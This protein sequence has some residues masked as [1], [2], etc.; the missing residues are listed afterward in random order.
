MKLLRFFYLLF[1]F[2]SLFGCIGGGGSTDDNSQSFVVTPE[3]VDERVS[4]VTLL[5]TNNFQPAD[6]QSPVI[7]T[8]IARDSS[9]TPLADV[10]VSL[11]S[12]SDFAVFIDAKGVTGEN[13]R[14]TTGIV[15]SEAEVFEITAIAGG[16]LSKSAMVN[17]IAPVE[18]I[19]LTTPSTVL[20]VGDSST[21]IATIREVDTLTPL[22]R[23]PL[24]VSVSGHASVENVPTMSNENGQAIFTVSDEIGETVELTVTSGQL[25]KT[26]I[27]YFGAT[28]TL[29][30]ASINTLNTAQ[31]TALL[32]SHDGQPIVGETI[33]FNFLGENNETLTPV[34][35]LT[36][37]NGTAVVT[38]TD[39]A[40]D[41]GIVE[42]QASSGSLTAQARVRF[43]EILVDARVS[44]VKLVVTD[45]YQPA[46]GIDSSTINV[47]VHD[48]N[49]TPLSGIAVNLVSTSDF[50]L[51]ENLTGMTGENGRFTTTV[52]STVVESF[53]VTATGGGVAS[54]P[55]SLTFNSPVEKIELSAA[56][57]ILAV[58]ETTTITLKLI[59]S[60]LDNSAESEVLLPSTPFSVKTT[61]TAQL[62]AVPTSTDGNGQ[63]IFTVTNSQAETVTLT[64]SSGLVTQNLQLFFGA[65]LSLLPVSI[66]AINSA[67]LTAILKDSN[68]TPIVQQEVLFHF[69]GKNNETLTPIST[70]TASDGTATVTI[71]DVEQNGGMAQV[72]AQS[73]LLSAQA[74]VNFLAVFGENR[75]FNA[76]ANTRV[77]SSEQMAT[78]FVKM[79]DSH[80]LP[81]A[82]QVVNFTVT[83]SDGSATTAE[84]LPAEG[85]SDNDGKISAV[86]T[87]SQ[88][89]NVV[90]IVQAGAIQQQLPLYFGARLYFQAV[91][92]K[93]FANGSEPL[94]LVAQLVDVTGVGIAG[95]PIDFRLKEGKAILDNF[96]VLSDENGRVSVNITSSVVGTAV[97]A[98]QAEIL[99]PV[100]TATVNFQPNAAAQLTLSGEI[101]SLSLNGETTVTATV[102]DQ[103]GNLVSDGTE[104]LFSTN[105]GLIAESGL[106]VAGKT[107]VVFSA[108]TQ[109]GLATITATTGTVSDSLTLEI[110]PGS[111]GSIEV[112]SIEPQV[113]GIRGSGVAQ[114][115]TIEFLVKDHLGNPIADGTPINFS[116][117][118]TTLGGGETISTEGS[119]GKTARDTSHNGLVQVTLQSGSV[120]GNIDVIAT[121]N[122]TISTVARVTIVGGM[123]EANH[124][125]LAMEYRNL[126]GG[127][128]FG[129]VDQIIAYVGDRFGNIVPDNTAVSFMTEGGTIG[130]SIGDG[131]F[132]TTTQLGQASAILQTARPT[133]PNLGGIATERRFG[134]ECS[135]SYAEVKPGVSIRLLCGNPGLVT[136]VAFTTGSESFVDRNGN[137]Y[138]D[139]GESFTDV[140]EPFIDGNDSDAFEEGELYI[141][142]NGNGR[143]DAGNNQFDGPGGATPNTTIWH[144]IRVLFSA[145]S[146][147]LNVISD[148]TLPFSIPNGE[149]RTFTVENIS[150]SY[151][152]AL[153]E[154]TRFQV[155]TNNGVLG[156]IT[157]LTFDDNSGRGYQEEISFTLSSNPPT[158]VTEKDA[159]GNQQTRYEYPPP[160]PATL[161]LTLT[162][163]YKESGPGGNGNQELI[164]S[165]IINTQ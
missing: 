67:E 9:N 152:N 26:L 21:I 150:D 141:D 132:T 144:S 74:Q 8:V 147:P 60:A 115:A 57:A 63:A 28:L 99:T 146:M 88:G 108:T 40:N 160:T 122:D 128:S 123:P 23:A 38:V 162:S 85:V 120:A 61:G 97:I 71:S 66:N 52:T 116:L 84:I 20:A 32:K 54:Q 18:L 76:S 81:L 47:I 164:I 73:G 16:K 138:Y 153:V 130:T 82:G 58:D 72:E 44:I 2:F 6:G 27:L 89:G 109:A 112:Q 106:T 13:G 163:P 37:D 53:E 92:L 142:V 135:G 65:Q 140:S 69:L 136:I 105:I 15:S 22:P 11:T 5:V 114:S 49:N 94:I 25:S 75:Q 62:N 10:E 148:E 102:T 149:S 87:H 78:I 48:K 104:V 107:S 4:G 68:Q 31:L 96:R 154:G 95:I 111:A 3:I 14:F 124:L 51:F 59:G 100:A 151:G 93:G 125:S 155:T 41:G 156:G 91:D 113:I 39:L 117:G 103:Q 101:D 121:V 1:I 36:R 33:Y 159:D 64:A 7:L 127:V 165:G 83:A 129:L 79:T 43:G 110:Q 56:P 42:I 143:F 126:A 50:A 70:L 118:N 139:S 80:G 35:S 12:P 134:Y 133:T 24:Q 131:A 157:D 46:N 98:A 55:I 137:G 34:S 161:T 30:P 19:E 119:S 17:F 90:V 145:S 29:V 45:N 77:L 158:V 86:V